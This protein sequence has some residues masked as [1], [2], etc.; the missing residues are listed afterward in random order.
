[1]YGNKRIQF[2]RIY[3][4]ELRQPKRQQQTCHVSSSNK[5]EEEEEHTLSNTQ[6][7]DHNYPKKPTPPPKNTYPKIKT[8]SKADVIP[9]TL[10]M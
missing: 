10:Q 3:M 8:F 1:M 9:Q 4:W 6:Q 2:L 7:F 5:E